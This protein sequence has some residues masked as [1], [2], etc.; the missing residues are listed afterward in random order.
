MF[1]FWF[2]KGTYFFLIVGNIFFQ[3]NCRVLSFFANAQD[4]AR[5]NLFF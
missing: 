5:A 4:S 1:N 2:C 3:L